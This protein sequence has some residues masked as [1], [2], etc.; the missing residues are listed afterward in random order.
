MEK[1]G[2]GDSPRESLRPG[3]DLAP[4][5]RADTFPEGCS[6]LPG[7]CPPLASLPPHSPLSFLPSRSL[8]R[9]KMKLQMPS[10]EPQVPGHR[11]NS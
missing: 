5:L 10:D 8:L 2:Q 9:T 4:L 3:R 1:E 11:N 6:L 7:P